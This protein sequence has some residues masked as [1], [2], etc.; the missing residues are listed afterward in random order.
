MLETFKTILGWVPLTVRSVLSIALLVWARQ[1][2]G[3]DRSDLVLLVLGTG[4][5][6]LVGLTTAAVMVLGAM[7]RLR[8]PPAPEE[9]WILSTGAPF[10]TGVALRWEGWMPLVKVD[11]KWERPEAAGGEPVQGTAS[12]LKRGEN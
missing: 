7:M 9:P 10:R 3:V 12:A 4:G 1:S 8:R 2:Y 6:V 5:L 11:L